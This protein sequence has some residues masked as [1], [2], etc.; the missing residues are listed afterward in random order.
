MQFKQIWEIT[1]AETIAF[2]YSI[3]ELDRLRKLYGGR[4]WMK[5]KG[6]AK[7]LLFDDTIHEAEGHWY[8]A[9]GIGKREIKIRAC[10]IK[11]MRNWNVDTNF[12]GCI[13]NQDYEA[14]LELWKYYRVLPD[15]KASTHGYLRIIDESGEDYLYPQHYFSQVEMVRD[16]EE[17]LLKAS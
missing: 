7:V 11:A 10:W 2:K 14:S 16:L 12:V 13:S 3:R 6:F 15:E 1:G 4:R 8:E 9:H 17:A 5:K